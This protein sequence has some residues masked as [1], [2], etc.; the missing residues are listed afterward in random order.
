MGR[1]KKNKVRIFF[2]SDNH[3]FHE[4]IFKFTSRPFRDLSHMHEEMIKRWNA[5]VR[6]G[7]TV[8]VVGDFTNGGNSAD[9]EWAANRL[10][11]FKIL[12]QGNHDKGQDLPKGFQAMV[13]DCSLVIAGQKVTVKH[14]PLRYTRWKTI[15]LWIKSFPKK[16]IRPKY[17][18]S[19]PRDAGQ[20]HM[21]GHTHSKYKFKENQIHVGCDAWKCTPVYIGEIA[22]YI[23]R[24]EAKKRLEK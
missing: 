17:I 18:K 13:R 16:P 23:S 7:D 3:F 11:G 19:M 14:Y 4:N 2:T 5:V 8:Y 22:S 12:V 24:R 20:Y 21:H 1:K 10:N 9:R 6:P 15:M